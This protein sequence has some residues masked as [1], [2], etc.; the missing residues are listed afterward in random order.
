MSAATS[1]ELDGRLTRDKLHAVLLAICGEV[2][3]DASGAEL[4]KFTNNAVF[5]LVKAP[6]VVRIAGSSAVRERIRTV[7]QVATWL[8][9]Q[10]IPA[11]RLWPD[12]RQ[13]VE[14][15]AYPATVWQFV[16]PTASRP[17]GAELADLLRHFHTLPEPP[18]PMPAWHPFEE[19]R[20]RLAEPEGLES[21]DQ[22]FLLGRCDELEAELAEVRYVLPSG[23]IHGDPFLGNLIPGSSGPVLCDFDGTCMGPREWDLTPVAVGKLRFN[24]NHDDHTPL[25][26]RYGFDVT[27]WDGFP[28][29]RRI[30]ELKLVTSVVPILR[31]NPSIR[32]QWQYR[33]ATF[34]R[35][36]VRAKWETYR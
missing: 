31:S 35:G 7:V 15:A 21:A 13:P 12:I 9:E 32:E 4:I 17:T 22:A 30:R 5:R 34:K 27:A 36:D 25:A 23:V 28:V 1:D 3:L 10:D 18:F 16:P 20:R 33:L 11:V 24:Y 29:L 26:A 19:I 6:A 8:A 14:A 2:G